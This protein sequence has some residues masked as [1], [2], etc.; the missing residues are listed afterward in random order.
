MSI[1]TYITPY[2]NNEQCKVL[3]FNIHPNL[4]FIL[5]FSDDEDESESSCDWWNNPIPIKKQINISEQL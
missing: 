2:F 4:Y 3:T 1:K 5:F